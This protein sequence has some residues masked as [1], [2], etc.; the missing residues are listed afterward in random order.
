MSEYVLAYE[1]SVRVH[2]PFEAFYR[3]LEDFARRPQAYIETMK[4]CAVLE[5]KI[6][7][8]RRIFRRKVEFEKFS[9]ED[10]VTLRQEGE[11]IEQVPAFGQMASSLYLV[12]VRKLSSDTICVT[13]TYRES[14]KVRLPEKLA[15]LRHRAWTE[16]DQKLVEQIQST[17]GRQAEQ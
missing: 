10:I 1:H 6:V 3:G 4:A 17:F 8:T 2:M 13:F 9:F 14:D 12:R 16:K 15:C 11:L 5:E 7:G